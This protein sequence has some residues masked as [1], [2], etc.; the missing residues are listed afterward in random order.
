MTGII[1]D[2]L[3]RVLLDNLITEVATGAASYYIGIGNS[4]DWDSSDTAP[5][6]TNTLREERNLRLQLQSIKSGEDVSYVIPRNNWALLAQFIAVGMITFQ[7]IQRLHI[8]F[9]QMITL[10]LCV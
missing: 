6:P 7:V 5:D 2:S 8:L 10:C 9:L 3:K 4:I 1:T